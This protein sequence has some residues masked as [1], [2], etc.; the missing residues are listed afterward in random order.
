MNDELKVLF[1]EGTKVQV[2]GETITVLPFTARKAAGALKYLIPL[3][4]DSGA[5]V[6]DMLATSGDTVLD[7]I[8]YATGKNNVS[9]NGTPW[10]DTIGLDEAAAL[11]K[12]ILEENSG[13]F[14]ERVLPLVEAALA[15]ESKLVTLIYSLGS[16]G[17][18]GV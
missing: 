9:I 18:D 11:L 5:G 6:L 3:I 7:L 14:V 16:K 4:K 15:P 8:E 12:A 2:Q 1:P 17:Q 10:I 13:F